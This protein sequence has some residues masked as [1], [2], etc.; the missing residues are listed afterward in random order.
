M[1]IQ[2]IVLSLML[3]ACSSFT[4]P[5][6]S[7]ITPHKIDVQQ[8]NLITPELREQVKVGMSRTLVRSIM[9]TPLVNDP[10]HTNRWDYVYR[11]EQKGKLVEQQ[12]M[13]LYFKDD[14]VIRVDD[15][16]MPPLAAAS[17]PVDP[18][19]AQ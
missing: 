10:F 5:T 1:R 19:S 18:P 8:G 6:L 13:V 12:H 7:S 14:V 11:L 15:D 4:L 9:G 3:A 16:G 17:E 2:L